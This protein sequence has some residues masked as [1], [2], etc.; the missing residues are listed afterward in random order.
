[1]VMVKRVRQYVRELRAAFFWSC[2]FGRLYW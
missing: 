2:V 1:M